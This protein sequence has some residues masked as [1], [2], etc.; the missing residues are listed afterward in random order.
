MPSVLRTLAAFTACAWLQTLAAVPAR[1]NT[2]SVDDYLAQVEKSDPGYRSLRGSSAGSLSTAGTATLAFRPQLYAKVEY[3]DDT[4][5]TQA[6]S[7]QGESNIKRNAAAGIQQQT[8]WGLQLQLE[9]DYQQSE[10]I[11][12]DPALVARPN[13][14]NVYVTP[15]YKLSL[16]Q[17]FLGR[18]DKAN[19]DVE[20]AKARAQAYG[21]A[22]HARA[23]LVDAE[24]KY[25]KL[26]VTREL[27]R[28]QSESVD[29]ARALLEFDSK[30]ASRHLID[31]T[32]LLL[33]Q[34]AVKGKE[35]ELRAMKDEVSAAERAFNSA[36]GTDGGGV[37]EELVVPD[38]ETLKQLPPLKRGASRGDTLAAEQ[39]ALATQAGARMARERLRP[40]LYLYG[41][42]FAVGLSFTLPLDQGLVSS[43]SSGYAEQEAA[44][45]LQVARKR[46]DED[47]EWSELVRK[48]DD[49]KERY[50]LALDLEKIQ[51]AKFEGVKKRRARGLT[52]EDQVFQ[53]ELDYLGA[54]LNRVQMEG[55]V[56]G[57]R[58][59]MKL[60]GGAP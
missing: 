49:A 4:R 39:A 16:W 22:Y 47:T 21:D 36:R 27:A 45:E 24:G 13:L 3:I 35:L 17:N 37:P 26:A 55:L 25:W 52:I 57:L 44:A 38:S 14:L 23:S 54:A 9:F 10:L 56:L 33:G 40:D 34:A 1:A 18:A 28:V 58:A 42:V 8:P 20:E 11:G 6:P 5:T 2:L 46:L 60:F 59:Q 7:V 19:R 29:R 43:V 12:S 31:S 50:A 32:E 48:F 41:S 51:R 15:V 53:Y 30:K